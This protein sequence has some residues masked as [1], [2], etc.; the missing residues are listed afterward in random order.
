MPETVWDY[1]EKVKTSVTK[2]SESPAHL[3]VS[4][5]IIPTTGVS[6]LLCAC[7]Y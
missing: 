6:H 2:A 7:V 4:S 5:T 1:V 3:S